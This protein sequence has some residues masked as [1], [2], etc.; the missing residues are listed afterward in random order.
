MIHATSRGITKMLG[1]N[2]VFCLM[3]CLVK[4]LAECSAWTTTLFRFLMGMGALIILGSSAG[5]LLEKG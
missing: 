1:A 4:L 3:A 2:L 5:I